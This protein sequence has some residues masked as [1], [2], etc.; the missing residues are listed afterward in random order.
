INPP[1]LAP[2]YSP[3]GGHCRPARPCDLSQHIVADDRART[4]TFH[5]AGPDP[6]F[7]YKLALPIAY[8]VPADSPTTMARRPLPGTGPYRIAA[9]VPSP[10]LVLQRTPRS[11][12]SPPDAP[13]AGSPDR[14]TAALAR[15]KPEQLAAV[16]RGTADV[17]PP[18]APPPSLVHTLELRYA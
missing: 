6:D 12:V 14:V 9:F 16:E 11:R 4:V 10:P 2:V 7:L 8:V 5:L 17:A 3:D 15:S 18:P 1:V 13:P